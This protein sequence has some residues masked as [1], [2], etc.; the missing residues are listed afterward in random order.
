MALQPGVFFVETEVP[1]AGNTRAIEVDSRPILI[2]NV[3]GELFAVENQCTHA[4]VLLT[5]A[6]LIEGEIEC[7]VHGARFDA[8]TGAV[9]CPPA[10]RGLQSFSIRQVEGG[11]QIK[12]DT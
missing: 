12:L 6:R 9:M 1:E 7:P 10:R 2:C 5:S 11:V 8:K 3:D 4:R